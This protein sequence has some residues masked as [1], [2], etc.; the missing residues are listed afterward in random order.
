VDR[1]PSRAGQR[2]YL[3]L[4][5]NDF[6]IVG[7]GVVGLSVARELRR[8][9]ATV[10]VIDSEPTVGAHASGRNSGV[11]H[12]GFYYA[13]ESLK[14]RLTRAGNALLTAYCL[15]RNLPINRCGK[16]VIATNEEELPRLGELYRRGLANGVQLSLIDE[17]EARAIEP[18]AKVHQRAI[19]SPT[20]STIDPRALMDSLLRDARAEGIEV[21]LGTAYADQNAGFLINAAGL[22]ALE[23]AQRFGFGHR[24]RLTPVEGRYLLSSEPPGAFRTNLYPVPDPSLPFLGVHFTVTADG[25][26]K[27]GPTA[28][29]PPTREEMVRRASALADVDARDYGEWGVTGVRAQLYDAANQSLEMDFV[30]EG[31]GRSLHILNIVS[32]GLTCAFSLAE[33]AVTRLS[34]TETHPR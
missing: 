6:L 8:R 26:V 4:A 13:P 3:R 12:A 14:A 20:T 33:Y 9:G 19:W 21:L 24:Y 31:D 18:R 7:A 27:I 5:V 30:L 22:R 1:A 17:A 34:A 10:T 16:L 15:E 28:G 25:R 2:R 11:L 29:L 23:I 32:P